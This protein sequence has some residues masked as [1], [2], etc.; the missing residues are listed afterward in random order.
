MSDRR[1]QHPSGRPI[2][3]RKIGVRSI[4]RIPDTGPV[5]PGL[6][7]KEGAYAVGFT[8]RIGADEDD[9]E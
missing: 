5:T 8:A 2:R 1:P 7:Q 9:D 3:H 6:Q 4:W